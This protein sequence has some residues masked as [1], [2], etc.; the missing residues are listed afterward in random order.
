M[1]NL[2]IRAMFLVAVTL[3]FG[4]GA[5]HGDVAVTFP[6]SNSFSCNTFGCTFLGDNGNQSEPLWTAG[7]FVTE[8]FFNG[9]TS[10]YELQ[11]D[12]FLINNLGGILGASYENDL[13]VN[14]TLV[15][16]FLVSD[17]GYC[18]TQQ[19][20]TGDFTF[21]AI[22]GDGTYALSI[23]LPDTV[24]GGGGNEIYLAPGSAELIGVPEPASLMLLGSGL[25]FIG[26]LRRKLSL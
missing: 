7:D 25:G 6:S 19:E 15:G 12:F 5:A 20:Y 14:S 4:M 18:G 26:I 11:Y 1:K 16:S 22:E 9:P 21:A 8:I 17:C 13:Y 10:I 24:P 3:F 23:I 2:S